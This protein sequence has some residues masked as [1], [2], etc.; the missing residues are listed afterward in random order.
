MT[1]FEYT[2]VILIMITSFCSDLLREIFK[3]IVN[4]LKSLLRL[5]GFETSIL[6]S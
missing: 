5:G 4:F 2:N 1:N 3:K 6:H